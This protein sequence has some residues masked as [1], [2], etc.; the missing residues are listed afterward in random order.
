MSPF[1]GLKQNDLKRTDLAEQRMRE[2]TSGRFQHCGWRWT[3][4]AF[5][6]PP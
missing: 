5:C 4:S 2:N 3:E 6:N 1:M